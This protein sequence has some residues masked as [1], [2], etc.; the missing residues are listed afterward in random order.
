VAYNVADGK[1]LWQSE[2]IGR[3]GGDFNGG[4][5]TPTLDEGLVYVLGQ[6][7]DLVCLDA[8]SG[9]VVW[10]KSLTGDFGGRM[11][12]W[13]FTESPLVDGN[14]LLATPGGPQGTMVALDKKTGA[15]LWQSR[16]WTDAT[17]YSSIVPSDFGG[18][19]HYVQLT[20]QSVAGV[21]A[22]TGSLL[23]RAPRRGATAVVPTPIVAGDLVFVTSGYNIGCNLFKL[24]RVGNVI[25]SQ[26]VYASRDMV[27][28]HGGV[29]LLGQHLYGHSDN[30]NW[31]CMEL[32]TGRVAWKHQGVGKGA[33]AYADGHLYCRAESGNGTVALV[34]ATPQGYQEKG[35]FD[36]PDRSGKNSWAHPVIA[37]GRLYLRDQDVLLCYDVRQK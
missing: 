20:E 30:G 7:G 11:Q 37:G 25:A 1:S 35:R 15:T 17:A 13:N 21:D 31:T 6:F 22:A 36:Q 26:Q 16:Q 5:S 34:A 14:K 23:W 24:Q 4:K 32:R 28:H 3:P 8:K 10:K 2:V 33:M 12:Q 19:R 29:I 27:N 18:K 9:K